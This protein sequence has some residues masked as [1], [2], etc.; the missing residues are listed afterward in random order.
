MEKIRTPK[1]CVCLLLPNLCAVL[2]FGRRRSVLI[3]QMSLTSHKSHLMVKALV[4]RKAI[5]NLSNQCLREDIRPS[6][7]VI[8]YY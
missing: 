3:Y 7:K 8:I 4:K 5:A 1:I 6:F 2:C